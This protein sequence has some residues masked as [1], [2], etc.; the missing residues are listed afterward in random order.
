MAKVTLA[1][2]TNRG[3]KGK[4]VQSLL[5]LVAHS[6]KEHELHILV[7][8][9]GYTI[10][11]QRN[12]IVVQA[13]KNKSDYVLMVDDDMTFP[14]NTLE[15]LLAHNKDAIGVKSYS[16][17]LP[18]C[19]TVGLM[20]ENG[21]YMHPDNFPFLEY[22]KELFKAYFVGAG[23]LL[24]KMSVFEKIEK[25]YFAF[26]TYEEEELK[27]M[28]KN[29]EDGVFCAKVREA[30]VEVY[31]DPTLPIGHLGEMEYKEIK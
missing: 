17:V 26:E 18:L 12:Y 9:R 13:Q 15:K 1:I 8:E 21:K 27:G 19:P 31:C 6:S 29:G 28:V 2:P 23:V 24:I 4:T 30:G 5:E 3:V 10:A 7:S 22:P 25:P 20:D 11:E 16:K 14:P